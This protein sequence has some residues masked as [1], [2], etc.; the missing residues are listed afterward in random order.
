MATPLPQRVEE[1]F[2]RHAGLRVLFLFDP[3]AVYREAV[4]T[5]EHSTI[6]CIVATEARFTLR[7]RLYAMQPENRVFLYLPEPRP[8]PWGNEPLLDLWM[9]NRELHIDR[10]GE[11][12]DEYNLPPSDRDLVQQY[13]KG[14][15]EYKNRRQFLAPLLKPGRFNKRSLTLGLAAYHAQNTF[16]GVRFRTVPQEGQVLAALMVGATNPDAFAEYKAVCDE[17]EVSGRLGML[18]KQQFDLETTE[19]SFE[20]V[21]RA[22]EVMKYNLLMRPVK[23]V[24]SD[25]RYRSFRVQST[26]VLNQLESLKNAWEESGA[27]DEGPIEVLDVVA[28]RI[29]E[30]H[31]VSEYGAETTF[32]YLT[33]ALRGR[34]IDSALSGI[35]HQPSASK[36]AV[37]PLRDAGGAVAYAA[38]TAW[39]VASMYQGLRDAKSTA[40]GGIESFV[41]HYADSLYQIDT[42]YRKA[43]SAYRSME[44][45]GHTPLDP[46]KD[47]MRQAL[48]DY[49]QDF[50]QPVNTKWQ[51]ALEQEVTQNSD[52]FTSRRIG[53]GGNAVL[54]Q[55]AFYDEYLADDEHKTAVIVS[56]AL[57]YEVAKELSDRLLQ[58]NKRTETDLAPML[59]A[60]PTVT[61]LGMA[62]LLPHTSIELMDGTPQINGQSTEGTRNR[63]SLLASAHPSPATAD[64]FDDIAGL[65]IED[66]RKL[67]KENRLV[68]IYHNRIDA[69]GDDRKT[70]SETVP[71]IDKTVD[72]LHQ[73]IRT[74]NNWN[75]YRIAVVADH[76][77]LY[78]HDFPSSEDN[79]RE[80]FLEGFPEIEGQVLRGN[81]SVLAKGFNGES[82]RYRFPL[83]SMSDIDADLEVCV[84]R[85]VNR[86]KLS[87][88]SKRYV[89]GGASLQ[90][91]I[92]PALVV[93]KWRKDKAEKVTPRLLSKDRVINSGALNIKIVQAEAVSSNRKARTLTAAL[94]A[95]G[96]RIS[97]LQTI[98]LDAT[99]D[100]AVERTTKVLLTLDTKANDLNFCH[101]RV[102]DTDDDL[103]PVIE[104][105][106]SIQRY[107]EQD[108]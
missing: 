28:S 35:I 70:E 36:E 5:W 4:D 15:L 95:E 81:R 9:A 50:V 31:L 30:G 92:V 85:A 98:T 86:Y 19:F 97:D 12:M 13:Y 100:S 56:D 89:H 73:L 44:E 67:F 23:R 3:D 68:Y 20:T 99:S 64:T 1:Q 82:A 38:E 83:R 90:E 22:G 37:E 102:F 101:L 55:G 40:F 2:D 24:S 21:R 78:D 58:Q 108:F 51:S 49:R 32:G 8:N 66:G 11:F 16:S 79:E 107:F 94:Y 105:R 27:L 53:R 87:G 18:L 104:Q 72:E 62:H 26:L 54:R 93:R 63:A 77:F 6:E 34:R 103:N 39:H 59:A 41:Q 76:G 88:A 80:Q 69:T 10:V 74:L 25:D 57:R 96:E 71:A 61:S 43:I 84:P 106:Y 60:L 46:L 65:S 75:V 33:P 14:E 52:A 29:D 45:A 7:D 47:V 48:D 17:L 42:H 91:M